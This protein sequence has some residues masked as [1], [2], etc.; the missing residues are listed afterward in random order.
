[1]FSSPF[2]SICIPSFNR[3]ETLC[4]CLDSLVNQTYKNFE[5]IFVDDGS[6]DY[7]EHLVKQYVDKLNLLYIKKKNGG[8][9]TALNV[10]IR[11][12]SNTE[13]FM[14]LDSDDWLKNDSLEKFFNIWKIEN[15]RAKDYLCGIM[16]RCE[17]QKGRFI[18]PRFPSSP[19][20]ID[21]ITFHFGNI[22]Y[23]DCNECIRTSIIKQYQ[24]PE[25]EQS[26][27]VPEFYIFDQIG[28]NYSLYCTNDVTEKKE[29]RADGITLN[30]H[31]FYNRNWIGFFCALSCRLEKV[32]PFSN[33]RIS[34]K[35]IIFMWYEYWKFCHYDKNGY[36]ERVSKITIMGH[37]GKLLYL[38][39]RLLVALSIK[40]K[41]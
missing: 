2:F 31:D 19:Y 11:L 35:Q 5:V 4:R 17:D 22:D 32:V 41:V 23:G 39:K 36:G 21:Y 29:Y 14:I 25:P 3:A 34:K 13:L 16:A 12:A 20:Y 26:K 24:F 33:G 28:V 9:H 40:E 30:S 37:I 18:G 27:F 10:G 8:K 6:T 7:T 38:F 1:M 15:I